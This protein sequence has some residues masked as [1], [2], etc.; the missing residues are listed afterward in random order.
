[1]KFQIKKLVLWPRS[2]DVKPRIVSFGTA[3]VNVISGASRTGK[4]AII[5]I[6]DYCLGADRCSI[7]VETIRDACSWFGIVVETGEGE[8]L[9]ARREPGEQKTTGDM[10]VAEGERVTIPEHTPVKNATASAVKSQLDELSG[11]TRL[12]FDPDQSGSGFR[13]RPSFRDLAAFNF[14]P[15]NIVANPD[16]LYFKA[17]T[18]EHR[19]KLKTI[20]PYVL[21]AITAEILAAKHELEQVRRELARKERELERIRQVSDRW[22][23]ELR[24]WAVTARELGLVEQTLPD[25]LE[26]HDLLSLLR[27]AVLGSDDAVPSA[28]GI[29]EAVGELVA[30][31][32]EE[33]QVDSQLR[34]LRRRLAEMSKLKENAA[35]FGDALKIQRDR[36]GISKWLHSL[37]VSVHECPICENPLED[38]AP[39][40]EQLLESLKE[41]EDDVRIAGSVPVSFDREL[42]RVKKDID[43][44]IE[45]LEGIRI[46]KKEVDTRSEEV[47]EV[48]SRQSEIARFRGRVER[49]LEIHDAVGDDG[50]LS[51]VV[52]ELKA[53]ES[54]LAR[55]VS[56]AGVEGRQ[57]R[58]LEKIAMFAGRLLP[59]LDAERPNDPIELLLA[60]LTLRV[61]GSTREDYLWEIGSGA[62][63]LAYHVA[64]SLAL[65]QFFLDASPSPVPGFLVYDQPSQVY[66]PRRLA[67]SRTDDS[68]VDP[69]LRDED[70]DAVR[71]VFQTMARVVQRSDGALQVLVLD[72]AGSDVWGEIEGVNLVEEWREGR[73][74]I[75]LDWLE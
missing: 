6:I 25:D 56:G 26:R 41:I 62:N 4:S 27:D 2:E 65:Q 22:V 69:Q 33:S 20:F 68:D 21:N 59:G 55:K 75:P 53:R 49:G 35:N 16:V 9:F 29:S 74:L 1:M 67:R 54:A 46:R 71:M 30:L 57:K 51:E 48:R 43:L 8:K 70:V 45:R 61:K 14:Q 42:V 3:C 32:G 7:P 17:D 50:A 73:K 60:D 47:R 12:D 39:Q 34:V 31:Q 66:F 11:L 18:Y 13:G 36:L 64:V 15:Q 52:E 38:K 37:E 72:H 24:A 19:E 44:C 63:W 58:A 23:S 40:L 28:M 10:Y 5:P